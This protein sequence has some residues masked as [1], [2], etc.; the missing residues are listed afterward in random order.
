MKSA[1][2]ISTRPA[3]RPSIENET[4][5][6]AL[7][8]IRLTEEVRVAQRNAER[9]LLL[10]TGSAP[11]TVVLLEKAW[12]VLDD[13]YA[14]KHLDLYQEMAARYKCFVIAIDRVVEGGNEHLLFMAR[15]EGLTEK[16]YLDCADRTG[17]TS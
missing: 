9:A 11:A 13:P 4:I 16:D 5:E 17:A 10:L 7:D 6:T 2:S 8:K 14:F 12:R 1:L 3:Q 15:A